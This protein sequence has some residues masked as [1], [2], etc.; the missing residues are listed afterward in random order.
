M[1][2]DFVCYLRLLVDSLP[3]PIRNSRFLF[4][5][6]RALFD[7]PKELFFFR[8]DYLKGL[9]S[10][11]SVYYDSK[12]PLS[13]EKISKTTDINSQH[14]RLIN[15]YF[16]FHNP[17]SFLDA[18]CGSGHVIQ[19]LAV[20]VNHTSF[21]GIDFYPP[22]QKYHSRVDFRCGNL[23]DELRKINDKSIEF[24]L[25]AHVIEHLS[26]PHEVVWHLKR[27]SSKCL[28]IICPLE[29]KF[30]WGMNYHINFFPDK[31]AFSIFL[32]SVFSD[33]KNDSL[34]G[35]LYENMGDIMYVENCG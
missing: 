14:W 22:L 19:S 7:L 17:S 31:N 10:D 28:V 9:I 26:S 23:L 5:L 20:S 15:Y 8:S 34:E 1:N 3:E 18:G 21:L 32:S 6:A 24:V 29:K 16:K 27:I 4:E 12:S 33:H 13:I 30:T 25:C 11:L 35:L 2:R